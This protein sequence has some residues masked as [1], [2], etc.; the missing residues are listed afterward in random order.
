MLAASTSQTNIADH[1]NQWT[2]V[3]D[4]ADHI[5]QWIKTVKLINSNIYKRDWLYIHVLL[6]QS[7]PHEYPPLL[8]SLLLHPLYIFMNEY[9]FLLMSLYFARENRTVFISGF[10]PFLQL[11]TLTPFCLSP[12]STF[13]NKIYILGPHNF[14]C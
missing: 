2:N 3:R 4:A 8:P 14:F 9:A 1:D 13:I 6:G 12:K 11:L 10:W 5:L 7:N